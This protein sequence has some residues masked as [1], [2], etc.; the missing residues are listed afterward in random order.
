MEHGIEDGILG[1]PDGLF[2]GAVLS[3]DEA[4]LN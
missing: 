1:D 4:G 3:D 2:D